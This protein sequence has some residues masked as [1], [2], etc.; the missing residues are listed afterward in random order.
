MYLRNSMLL[1]LQPKDQIVP[2]LGA[3]TLA[4][5]REE[6]EGLYYLGDEEQA[7]ISNP[8]CTSHNFTCGETWGPTEASFCATALDDF[9]SIDK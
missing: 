1:W 2:E 7:F 9:I 8:I 3:K 6:R 5:G 4:Y